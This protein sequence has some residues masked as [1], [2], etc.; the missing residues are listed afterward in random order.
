MN[1]GPLKQ[2]YRGLSVDQPGYI[3]MGLRAYDP[4]TGRWLSPDP[5]GHVGSLSLYDYCDNDPL[6]VFDPDGRFGK[7]VWNG[8]QVSSLTSSLFRSNECFNPFPSSSV[9][10]SDAKVLRCARTSN[11]KLGRR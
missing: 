8:G 11:H 4:Q 3:Q 7:Q 1:R 9:P 5:A 10:P 6:N 2:E